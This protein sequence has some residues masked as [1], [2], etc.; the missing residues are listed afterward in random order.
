MRARP[1]LT[2]GALCGEGAIALLPLE[3]IEEESVLAAR[4]QGC[5][6]GRELLALYRH[7]PGPTLVLELDQER[8]KVAL[9]HRPGQA[10]GIRRGVC[11]PQLP[12]AGRGPWAGVIS[13]G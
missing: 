5:D 2:C 13:G 8:V 10:Q 7:H 4:V 11:H 1:P 9:G 6:G 3:P 12:K